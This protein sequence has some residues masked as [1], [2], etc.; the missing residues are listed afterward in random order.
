MQKIIIASSVR[1]ITKLSN[2]GTH[3]SKSGGLPMIITATFALLFLSLLLGV[4]VQAQIDVTLRLDR[5]EATLTDSVQLE[6]KVSGTRQGDTA[7]VFKGLDAFQVTRGGTASRMEMVNGRITSGITYTYFAQPQKPGT[8][9]IGPAAVKVD[10]QTLTSNTATLVVK[11]DAQSAGPGQAPVFLE[12]ALSSNKVY[13]EQQALYTLK[14]FHR[15]NVADL[16]LN[17]PEIKQVTLKQFGEPRNYRSTQAGVTYGVLEVRYVIWAAQAGPYVIGPG[18]MNMTLRQAGRQSLLNGFFKDPFSAFPAG[19]PLSVTTQP[20]ELTV[21]PLPQEDRPAGF[22]GLVG[23]FKLE[24]HLDPAHIETGESAT[25]TVKISGR[26]NITRIPDIDLPELSFAQIYSD[27]PV[28][29]SGQDDH[30]LGGTKTM[31]WALVPGQAGRFDLPD[32]AVSFFNPAAGRYKTLQSPR[33]TLSVSPGK[34]QDVTVF[35]PPSNGGGNGQGSFK[36]EI[37]QVGK[38]ILPIHTAAGD[39]SVPYRALFTGW[40]FW[41]ALVGPAALYGLLWMGLRS[42]RRPTARIALVRSRQAFKNFS[43][44]FQEAPPMGADLLKAFKVYL[45]DRF[46]LSLGTVT[47]DDAVRLLQAHDVAGNSIDR[48]GTLMK[49]IEVAVYTGD[50]RQNSEAGPELLALIK[51]LEKEIR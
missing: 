39:L 8:F 51:N 47:A 35:S 21:L 22:S 36:Q 34:P 33:H 10:G 3:P 32:L 27:Q 44:Q 25:L 2:S 30:G 45:N 28:L 18:K 46:S 38:D 12:A 42:R 1:Q 41:F 49:K 50:D 16:S 11:A 48:I 7:P 26:G 37:Q 14:L 20:L 23:D 9:V 31:K 17:L 40:R 13:V 5:A 4:P 29:E 24:S 15:V 43:K 19:R 6:V